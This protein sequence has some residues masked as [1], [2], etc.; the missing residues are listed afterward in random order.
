MLNGQNITE[1]V[2]WIL[3][4][5]LYIARFAKIAGR[6]SKGW[7]VLDEHMAPRPAYW[8]LQSLYSQ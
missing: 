7:G 3:A 8:R 2:G 5:P 1:A 6:V 4:H